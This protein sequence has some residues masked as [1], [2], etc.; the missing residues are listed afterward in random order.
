MAC[1]IVDLVDAMNEDARAQAGAKQEQ[2]AALTRL[3]VDGGASNNDLLMQTQADLLNVAV[4]KPTCVET[5]GLGAAYLAG[6]AVGVFAN[7]DEIARKHGIEKTFAPTYSEAQRATQLKGWRDAVRR[8]R[9]QF[10][11]SQ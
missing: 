2:V 6:L 8:A 4:D 5:T 1:Q 7:T 11:T 3:R 10:T 9:S